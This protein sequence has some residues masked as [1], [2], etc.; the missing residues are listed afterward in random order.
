MPARIAIRRLELQVLAPRDHPAPSELE[1][2]LRDAAQAYLPEALAEALGSWSGDAVLRIRRLEVDVTLDAGFDPRVF[3]AVLA[4]SVARELLAAS[5]RGPSDGVL[6]YPSRV[7][8][9]AELL[10]ALAEGRA[11]ERWWLR[12][13]EGLRF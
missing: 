3:T 10:E 12:D 6:S 9:L 7:F 5:E 1:R 11:F 8:Y 2:R 4:K 13:A